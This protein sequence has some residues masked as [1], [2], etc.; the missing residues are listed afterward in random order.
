MVI[1]TVTN[2]QDILHKIDAS[3]S[4]ARQSVAGINQAAANRSRRLAAIER[5]EADAYLG[6]AAIRVAAFPKDEITNSLGKADAAAKELIGQQEGHI[7]R[8]AEEMD[9][10]RHRIETLEQNRKAQEQALSEFIGKHEKAVAK[11]HDHLEADDSYQQLATSLEKANAIAERASAKLEQ[12][13]TDKAEKGAPYEADPLFSY[14]WERGFATREY[15]AFF[16]FAG[17]DRWVARLIRYR[18]AKLNY[19][20]LL[21]LPVRLREHAERVES[22]AEELSKQIEVYERDALEKAGVSRLRD[23]VRDARSALEK[24]DEQIAAAEQLHHD[25]IE[26]HANAA[27]G[28]DGPLQ[29]AHEIIA[30]ALADRSIPDLKS[31]AAETLTLED[32]HLVDDLI[33]LQRERLE[34]E[35]ED[36]AL[37]RSVTKQ[38][39]ILTQLESLRRRYKTARYD[40]PQSEF[41][42]QSVISV[43]LSELVRGAV[44]EHDAWRRIQKAQRRR[45]RNWS[46]DFGGAEWREGFG[47]PQD[48]GDWTISY[49]KY[50][51]PRRPRTPRAPRRPRQPR[52]RGGFKTGGGF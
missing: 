12:A 20:R 28:T 52:S 8:L 37:R 47:L 27:A 14:L 25:T 13:Q 30:A 1:A 3:I 45:K 4:E 16:L 29:R 6:I 32:D 19:E 43:I 36:K 46:D 44:R 50:K 42:D 48:N 18:D 10:A 40:G 26:R 24:I 49:P 35:D 2:G 39:D 38:G 9:T 23:K 33:R 51:K 22:V 15:K 7:D 34:I 17:I 21:E 31:M 5:A 11:T 41:P